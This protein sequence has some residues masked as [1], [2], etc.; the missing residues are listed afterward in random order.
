MEIKTAAVLGAGA[1]GGYLISSLSEKL[2]DHFCVIAKGE[3]AKRLKRDGLVINDV[4]YTLN[5]KTPGEAKGVDVLFV[6]L[7]YNALEG[8]LED[9]AEAV[10][11][12]TMVVSLMNGI[13]SEEIIGKRIGMEHMLYAMIRISSTREGNRMWFEIPSGIYGI[14]L[15]LP[16]K[17]PS[18]DE[19]IGALVRLFEKTP[20][21]LH[22]SEDI[23]R[24]I[25]DKFALNISLNLPQAVLFVGAGAYNDSRYVKSV[26]RKLRLEAVAVAKEK[27]INIPDENPPAKYNPPQ[28]FSTLQDLLAG[29]HTEI[30]MFCGA[31]CRMGEELGVPTPCSGLVYD[32]IKA[33][34]EKNDGKF[35][36]D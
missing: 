4:Q 32:F 2:G 19:R 8:A 3:R 23:E 9:I 1:V 33:L 7:K 34:E 17:K 30:E 18:E 16:G 36:Y 28:K 14:Y 22:L 35:D 31:L 10:G 13:D 25:W 26:E 11:P 5:V 24:D 15:G 6:V 12:E 20:V 29:R 21:L 27:G